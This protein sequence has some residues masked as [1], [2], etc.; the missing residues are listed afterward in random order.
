MK[1][2]PRD[3]DVYQRIVSDVVCGRIRPGERL[4]EES[5]SA[6]WGVGRSA[7]RE[8]MFRLQQDG[9]LIRK[10]K[11]GSFIRE[12]D[13]DE[14]LEIYDIRMAVESLIAAKAC[15]N[16]EDE[17]LA[18]LADAA[19]R[20]DVA[21]E[22]NLQREGLDKAFHRRLWE[23]SGLRHAPRLMRIAHLHAR[24]SLLNQRLVFLRGTNESPVHTPDHRDVVAA[25][26]SREPD[27]A[28]SVMRAHIQVARDETVRQMESIRSRLET[29]D[30][31][32]ASEGG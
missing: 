4:G 19:A 8:A 30:E 29:L 16:A 23:V 31:L 24:C 10:D 20:V 32:T 1:T 2:K 17:S 9:L 12:I 14:L 22:E 6:R 11:V 5:L 25:V 28:A 18:E 13:D 26:R 27:H 7:V 15:E 21:R 3:I